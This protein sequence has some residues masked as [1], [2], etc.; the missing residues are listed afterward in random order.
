MQVIPELGKEYPEPGEIKDT[1]AIID[2]I[3]KRLERDYAPGKTLRQFHAK[4]H[5]CVKAI[6][7][8]SQDIPLHLRYG[9]LIPGKSYE[10]WIRFSNGNPQ[11]L[12]DRKADL[13]GMAIKLLNVPGDVLVNSETFPQSQD[14]LLV[15]YPTLMSSNVS[16][17]RKFIGALCRGK[18]ALLLF[19]LNPFNWPTLMR[20]LNSSK[21]CSD[22]FALQYWSVSPYRLGTPDQAVKY[23]ALPAI[24]N[25]SEKALKGNPDFLRQVMKEKL[26]SG[27]VNF[28]F[29]VQLQEDALTMPMENTCVEWKSAW[30]KVASITIPS[31][32]F[33]T[34]E[35]NAFGEGLA[36][37]PW[38]CLKENQPL[39]GINRARKAVYEA[40]S[41]F[42][43]ERNHN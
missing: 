23:S 9:F 29:M 37:S 41:K 38:H 39:G 10:A 22:V 32:D 11:V 1:E 42:R 3:K 15:G 20:I 25:T 24:K 14:F 26:V 6:F 31:Q 28:D 4:M 17:S 18:T 7:T 13:R 36:F 30:I 27:S 5:G 35:R 2:A 33:D 19:S 40:I 16:D 8:I 21:K 34:T 12:D 43:I